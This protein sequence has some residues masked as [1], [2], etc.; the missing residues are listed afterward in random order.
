MPDEVNGRVGSDSGARDGLQE[1]A[2]ARAQTR[3][4]K[5]F[6]AVDLSRHP[7]FAQTRVQVSYE[8]APVREVADVGETEK[9]RDE[10]DMPLHLHRHFEASR[11]FC[12]KIRARGRALSLRAQAS[13]TPV[14]PLRCSAE[15][16]HTASRHALKAGWTCPAPMNKPDAPLGVSVS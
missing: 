2:A 9:T 14:R 1:A 3:R 5:R 4:R 12:H 10:E 6:Y 11:R 13:R 8:R 7:G 16:T 15:A